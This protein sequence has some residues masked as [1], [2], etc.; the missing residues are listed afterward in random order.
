MKQIILGREPSD[1]GAGITYYTGIMG[2]DNH[3]TVLL[4]RQY[5]MPTDGT[6]KKLKVR[7]ENVPGAG[8]NVVFTL[9]KNGVDTA[10]TCTVAD[11]NRIGSDYVNEVHFSAGDLINYKC[12]TSAG[13]TASSW[14]SCIEFEGDDDTESILL[15][16]TGNSGVS[17]TV[18]STASIYGAAFYSASTATANGQLVTTDGTRKK[19][20]VVLSSSPG[21]GGTFTFSNGISVAITDPNTSGNNTADTSAIT[22]GTTSRR[23]ACTPSGGPTTST[24]ARW[25]IVFVPDNPGEF[26]IMGRISISTLGSNKY[27][28]VTGVS[29][30]TSETAYLSISE[31]FTIKNLIVLVGTV[32]GAGKS[33]DY[34]LRQNQIDTLLHVLI[35]DANNNGSDLANEVSIIDDDLLTISEIISGS[36]SAPSS[37]LYGFTGIVSSPGPGPSSGKAFGQ[38]AQTLL[39]DGFI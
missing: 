15:G 20:Y 6:L 21:G 38:N 29:S 10:L 8:K 5:P 26:L 1:Y 30:D 39:Q 9:Q 11:A 7:V 17:T 13:I 36:P 4:D 25:G 18:T 3:S 16:G 19:F 34:I 37:V 31:P 27:S 32:P 28:P 22:G 33:V 35:A 12:V 23:V 24:K 14:T 2:Y